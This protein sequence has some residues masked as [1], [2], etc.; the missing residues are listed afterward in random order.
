METAV[1]KYQNKGLVRRLAL[2]FTLV[3]VLTSAG[4]A[5]QSERASARN[6]FT[7]FNGTCILT[8]FSEGPNSAYL[9]G[10]LVSLSHCGVGLIA[11]RS[12]GPAPR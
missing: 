8:I 5:V 9:G 2:L 3:A 11:H 7:Y 4:M 10:G 12:G 6:V 1:L